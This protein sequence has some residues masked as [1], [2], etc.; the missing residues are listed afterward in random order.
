MRLV[1]IATQSAD[2]ARVLA[3]LGLGPRAPPPPD[4]PAA[5]RQTK[6]PFAG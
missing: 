4:R 3:E 2:A 5:P 6:L 1:E